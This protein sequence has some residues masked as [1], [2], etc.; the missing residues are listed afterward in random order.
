[1]LQ[2]LCPHFVR[3]SLG[4]QLHRLFRCDLLISR[5]QI[6]QQRL[7]RNS[8]DRQMMH[9]N[10]QPAGLISAKIEINYA[11]HRAAKQIQAG[12]L[13]FSHHFR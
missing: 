3:R 2:S 11:P 6:F 9:D 10:E 13:F 5:L 4:R 1:M 8:V 7:P 12:L